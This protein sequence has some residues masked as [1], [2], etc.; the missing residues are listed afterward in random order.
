MFNLTR[1]DITTAFWYLI[2]FFGPY[3][4][5]MGASHPQA[6]FDW[7]CLG[8]ALA[9]NTIYHGSATVSANTVNALYH[10]LQLQPLQQSNKE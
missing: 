8:V 6:W 4:M 2:S 10:K 5:C 9:G 7:H 3:A 1:D